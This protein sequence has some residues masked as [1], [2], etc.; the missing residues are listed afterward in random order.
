MS[1]SY[2]RKSVIG[3]TQTNSAA[4]QADYVILFDASHS[5]AVKAYGALYAALEQQDL[6]VTSRPG[7]KHSKQILLFVRAKQANVHKALQAERVNDWLQGIHSTRPDPREQRDFNTEPMTQSERLRVV[8]DLITGADSASIVIGSSPYEPVTAIFPPHDPHFNAKWLKSW[9]SLNK[10][11]L[12][13]IP[14]EQLN[15]IKNHFGEAIALYFE[16]LRC[17][18]I[19]SS[20]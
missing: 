14:D 16:F 2:L 6:Q 12:V 9:T 5:Q 20:L 10:D 17:A 15:N 4:I 18:P 19:A 13:A 1:S 3:D 11:T 7:A 8:Y